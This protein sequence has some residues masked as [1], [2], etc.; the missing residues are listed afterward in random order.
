MVKV[1]SSIDFAP[2]FLGSF[3]SGSILKYKQRNLHCDRAT[4][5]NGPR[6]DR[7]RSKFSIK[8]VLRNF[9]CENFQKIPRYESSADR[10]AARQNGGRAKCQVYSG[11][12]CGS[13]CGFCT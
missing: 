10:Q 3:L 2:F 8:K 1:L 4:M 5:K 13:K 6:R 7:K 12:E 9:F 11:L